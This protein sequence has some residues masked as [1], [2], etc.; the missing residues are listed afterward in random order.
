MKLPQFLFLLVAVLRPCGSTLAEEK[1]VV[2]H[3]DQDGG[4]GP[5][6]SYSVPLRCIEASPR[7]VPGDTAFPLELQSAVANAKRHLAEEKNVPYRLNLYKIHIRR[8]LRWQEGGRWGESYDRVFRDRW[9]ALFC[10]K[11][12]CPVDM[13][14]QAAALLDGT[15]LNERTNRMVDGKA[16]HNNPAVLNTSM[17]Q[18]GECWVFGESFI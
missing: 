3:T 17:R 16:S 7:W 6:Y 9:F 10:F 2:L 11:T 12:D 14:R 18:V 15:W 4:V 8:P 5:L 13:E 1:E